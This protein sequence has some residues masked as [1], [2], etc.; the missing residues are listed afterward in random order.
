[1]IVPPKFCCCVY[2]LIPNFIA[3]SLLYFFG[4]HKKPLVYAF[5]K[6]ICSI[7]DFLLLDGIA[8]KCGPSSD[9]FICFSLGGDCFGLMY[10]GAN[11][12]RIPDI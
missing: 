8:S 9:S 5:G 6:K 1:M 11:W 2:E 4:I 10:F 7:S 3:L 12:P